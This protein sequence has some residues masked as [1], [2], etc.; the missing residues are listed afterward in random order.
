[1]TTTEATATSAEEAMEVAI[2]AAVTELAPVVGIRAA[3]RAVGRSRA[4]H[5]RH[6]R[7]GPPPALKPRT[8]PKPQPRALSVTE[9]AEIRAQLNS[10]RFVDSA[11]AAVYATLLDEGTYLCSES[12]MYRILREHGEV[13][14]RRR[15]ATHPARVPPELA[16]TGPTPC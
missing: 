9:R 16:A 2:E 5:Y 15:Q 8:E 7:V 11:P 12:S 4:T 3:C 10:E 14:E 13:H 1:M 6:H